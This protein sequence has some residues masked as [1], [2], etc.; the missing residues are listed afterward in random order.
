[1]PIKRS[2]VSSP[3]ICCS[4]GSGKPFR[5]Q[6]RA[7][8]ARSKR[9]FKRPYITYKKNASKPQKHIAMTYEIKHLYIFFDT[10]DILYNLVA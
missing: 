1:M 6:T 4:V 10:I 5:L 8:A 7:S 3:N 9:E 2:N